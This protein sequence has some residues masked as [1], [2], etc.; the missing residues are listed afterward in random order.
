MSDDSHN[1]GVDAEIE[2]D[3]VGSDIGSVWT[4]SVVEDYTLPQFECGPECP[5]RKPYV[6]ITDPTLPLPQISLPLT[7]AE[8]CGRLYTPIKPWQTRLLLVDPAELGSAITASLD[9][10][11]IVH[12][13][14]AVLHE[15]QQ[16]VQYVA[17]SYTWGAALFPRSIRIGSTEYPITENLYAFI[18]RYRSTERPEYIWVDAICINQFD[19]DEKATQVGHMLA[20]F[21]RAHVVVIW[22]GEEGPNTKLAVHYLH[23][24]NGN[25]RVVR[26]AK[27]NVKG[28]SQECLHLMP[29]VL[30]GIEDLCSRSWV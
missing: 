22:L 19:L 17:L 10:V 15:K 26:I 5:L 30:S 6:P 13:S 3:Y 7:R 1:S 29:Q 21:E 4:E 28:H 27:R 23:W 2:D 9:V 25:E 16:R 18:Q 14:G 8:A 12:L 20:I 24:A 11:D